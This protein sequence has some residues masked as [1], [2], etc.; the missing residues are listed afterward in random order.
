MQQELVDKVKEHLEVSEETVLKLREE[1]EKL[2]KNVEC[3]GLQRFQGSDKDIR[4]YTGLPSY[5]VVITIFNFLQPLLRYLHLHR[6]DSKATSTTRMPAPYL[7]AL[8]PIDEFF[9]VLV[10]LHL[11]LLEVDLSHRFNVSASTVSRIFNT[12]ISFLNSQ[13]RPLIKWPSRDSVQKHLPKQFKKLFPTARCI[14][15]CTEIFTQTPSSLP[16]QSATYSLYKHHNTFK[17]LVAISPSGAV[18]FI[19]NLFCGAT[20]DKDISRRCGFLDLLEPGDTVLADKGFDITYDVMLHGARLNIPPFLK[21]CKQLSKSSVS[22]TRR[23][24]SLRIHVERAIGRIKQYHILTN[25]VPLAVVPHFECVWGVC[26]ALTLFHPPLVPDD[27][28]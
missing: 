26:C 23:I 1:N 10:R 5:F 22:K 25:I 2:K 21:K 19:S 15:D 9:L 6:P 8:Q 12:W 3:F 7:R 14:I 11:G 4:F 27:E 24:A 20:S 16:L 18:I 28:D 17:G 13:L